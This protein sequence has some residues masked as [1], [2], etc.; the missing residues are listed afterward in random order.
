M[1]MHQPRKR[2]TLIIRAYLVNTVAII[3]LTANVIM[4]K[5]RPIGIAAATMDTDALKIVKKPTLVTSVQLV[6]VCQT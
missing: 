6:L 2:R 4:C 1:Q 5:G 3:I